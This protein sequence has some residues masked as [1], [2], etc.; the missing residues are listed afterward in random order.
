MRKL[1][2]LTKLKR[3]FLLGIFLH[4]S[5]FLGIAGSLELDNITVGEAFIRALVNGSG[6]LIQI[7]LL[8]LTEQLIWEREDRENE[9]K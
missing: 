5:Y 1:K 9:Q 3:I 7:F 4:C 2:L 6:L 8:K